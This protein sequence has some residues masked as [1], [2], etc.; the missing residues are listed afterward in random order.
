MC[1]R[2]V[3]RF[4]GRL[5]V[6]WMLVSA[7][8][9]TALAQFWE[10]LTNPKITVPIQYPPQMGLMVK[11]VAIGKVAGT[12]GEELAEATTSQLSQTLEVLDRANLDAI[13][14]EQHFAL[15]EYVDPT[16]ASQLGKILGAAALLMIRANCREHQQALQQVRR[17]EGN[18]R[19][20]IYISRTT[21]T[22]NGSAQVVDLQTA[23]I[24]RA[25][26]LSLSEKVEHR[27]EEGQPE[28]ELP[29]NVRTLVVIKAATSISHLLTPYTEYTEVYFYDDKTCNLK[30]AANALKAGMTKDALRISEENV[31]A[32]EQ[33]T[34][35]K[36]KDR[37]KALGKAYY[38]LAVAQ[39][40][41]RDHDSAQENFQKVIQLRG[42]GSIVT[43]AVSRNLEMKNARL[44][45]Q[46]TVERTERMEEER[47]VASSGSAG[48]WSNESPKPVEK[49]KDA[50]GGANTNGTSP[51]ERLKTLENALKMG[52]ISKEEFDKKRAAI[53]AEM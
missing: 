53:L 32:C 17:G 40:L 36:E 8:G 23:K 43:A 7:A 49:A 21:V 51:I 13:L 15:S 1:L 33:T 18:T 28:F 22:L 3:Y 24:Y 10:S 45:M 4:A 34:F 44:E 20:P 46:R 14:R 29:E 41:N 12:C 50:S 42:S 39:M 48:G 6:G 30:A 31:R 26:P 19:I 52:L 37:N 16:S 5:V 35:K 27:S 2:I 9:N 25:V 11:K 38:N 47:A